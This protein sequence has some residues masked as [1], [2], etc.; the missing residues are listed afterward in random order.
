MEFATALK[1]SVLVLFLVCTLNVQFFVNRE[2]Y[3]FD[4]QDGA[5]QDFNGEQPAETAAAYLDLL[6][7][8]A[9]GNNN[10]ATSAVTSALTQ[11]K[12]IDEA[13]EIIS[14][15]TIQNESAFD[16]LKQKLY[17]KAALTSP[18]IKRQKVNLSE[19]NINSKTW[20]GLFTEDRKLLSELY[21]NA[22][23]IFEYGLG[24]STCIA[25][26]TRVPRYAGVD[27]DMYWVSTARDNVEVNYTVS[28][29]DGHYNGNRFRFYFADVGKTK[30][31]GKPYNQNLAK[32]AYDYQVAPLVTELKAFS[33]YLID[34]RYRVACACISFLH[35]L[36]YN[37]RDDV[38]NTVKVAI[39]DATSRENSWGRYGQLSAIADLVAKASELWVYRLKDGITE[40]DIYKLW[41]SNTKIQFRRRLSR[42]LGENGQDFMDH[43]NG[44][45]ST[46]L[47]MFD[48][49]KLET[50]KKAIA[51][52]DTLDSNERIS[53]TELWNKMKNGQEQH[54][55]HEQDINILGDLYANASSVFEFGISPISQIAV[56][57]KI[58][59]YFGSDSVASSL[60]V[61]RNNTINEELDHFR[62][63]LTDVGQTDEDGEPINERSSKILYDIMAPL[64]T[65][66]EAFDIY[67]VNRGQYSFFC[68]CVS[69]LHKMK[70]GGNTATGSI[71]VY[72][73]SSTFSKLQLQSLESVV[74]SSFIGDNIRIFHLLP[75]TEEKDIISALHSNNS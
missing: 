24:E 63:F 68:T 72:E 15:M 3:V 48:V 16:I 14:M 2:Q 7:N 70:Y 20:G 31:W 57:T 50:Y 23:S 32:I 49:I 71:V 65:E 69:L 73:K 61:T 47:S 54:D 33:V 10:E 17:S 1:R 52:P 38:K 29:P 46:R 58:P 6:S 37:K 30:E 67:V 51:A 53:N 4:V 75:N 11:N 21:L 9:G 12:L 13:N 56:H 35:A 25:A 27:S 36:K 8:D 66:N 42:E 26:H 40:E 55:L 60:S 41:K 28:T 44:D 62:F 22:T 19:W 45:D 39:H 18:G 5:V 43:H 34:G 59:R 64:V 74:A